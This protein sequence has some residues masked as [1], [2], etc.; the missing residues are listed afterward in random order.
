MHVVL[1]GI[2]PKEIKLFLNT[3][4][5]DEKWLSRKQLNE[6]V[7]KFRFAPSVSKSDVPRTFH[8]DLTVVTPASAS[9]ILLLHLPLL[10]GEYIPVDG[11][12]VLPCLLLL[13]KIKQIVLSPI[14]CTENVFDLEELVSEHHELYVRCY[15]REHFIPKMHMLV[16]LVEQV[17]Q[18]GPARHQWTM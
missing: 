11:H 15:G 13:C 3:A 10:I 16:H 4:I 8:S 18:H 5:H 2:I 12:L 14:L 7:S 6:S 1:E 9:L 17:R